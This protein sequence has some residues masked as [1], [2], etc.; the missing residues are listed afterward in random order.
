MILI[1]ILNINV[2]G[3]YGGMGM[4]L[5]RSVPNAA[6]MFVTFECVNNWLNNYYCEKNS[7]SPASSL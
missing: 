7:T 1:L 4:H 5:L 2:S 3:L 6:I